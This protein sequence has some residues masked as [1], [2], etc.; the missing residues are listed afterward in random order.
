MFILVLSLMFT[1]LEI[2]TGMYK[3]LY[4]HLN[5]P[6][7]MVSQITPFNEKWLHLMEITILGKNNYFSKIKNKSDIVLHF[8]QSSLTYGLIEH[9]WS[10]SAFAFNLLQYIV[11]AEVYKEKE[12][13]HRYI[14]GKRMIF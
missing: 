6:I 7:R 10:L 1:I 11:L 2:K 8:L 14:A 4:I 5:I 9:S 13:W 3:Y 12:A